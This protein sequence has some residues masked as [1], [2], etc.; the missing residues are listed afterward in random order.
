MVNEMC[1]NM[2]ITLYDTIQEVQR[3][4]NKHFVY[5]K[6]YFL[7]IHYLKWTGDNSSEG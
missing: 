2:D 1:N 5:N 6:H 7:D 4:S 3:K